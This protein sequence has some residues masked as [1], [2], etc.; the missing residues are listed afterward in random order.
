MSQGKEEEGNNTTSRERNVLENKHQELFLN[1][2]LSFI[3]V[4]K[5]SLNTEGQYVK[6]AHQGL[7]NDSEC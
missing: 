2:P 5:G 6:Q 4:I 7:L 1:Q 3:T